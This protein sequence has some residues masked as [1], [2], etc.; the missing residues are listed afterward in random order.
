M[1]QKDCKGEF[2]SLW[3]AVNGQAFNMGSGYHSSTFRSFWRDL[4]KMKVKSFLGV[5]Y[6]R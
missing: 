2:L 3:Y 5:I 6:G 4:E 1:L